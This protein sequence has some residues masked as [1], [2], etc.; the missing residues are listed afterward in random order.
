VEFILKS[1]SEKWNYRAKSR[2]P[3]R[4]STPTPIPM[5]V[6]YDVPALGKA[7]WGDGVAVAPGADVGVAVPLMG[8]GVEVATGDPVAVGVG[9]ELGVGVEVATGDP[10]GVGAGVV[11]KLKVRAVHAFGVGLATAASG[12]LVGAVG[13]TAT[14][15]NW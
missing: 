9:V 5:I 14:C 11:V 12:L 2:E 13:A 3:I 6:G 10:I 7:A 4:S 15:L 1:I 8:V